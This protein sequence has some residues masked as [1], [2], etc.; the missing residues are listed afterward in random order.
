M[1]ADA[2]PPS[3]GIGGTT[4]MR[5]PYGDG[6]NEMKEAIERIK[7]LLGKAGYKPVRGK[8]DAES[9][10]MY[11]DHLLKVLNDEYYGDSLEMIVDLVETVYDLERAL[12][13]MVNCYRPTDKDGIDPIEKAKRD[14]WLSGF[15]FS[16][17]MQDLLISDGGW[18]IDTGNWENVNAEVA[19]RLEE[20]VRR[21]PMLWKCF[22]MVG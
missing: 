22:F 12:E 3:G 11:R 19:I 20:R 5:G 10:E 14:G 13:R 15:D 4:T 21:H 16:L 18:V 6:G 17:L 8:N 7:N 2:F 9:E 1:K